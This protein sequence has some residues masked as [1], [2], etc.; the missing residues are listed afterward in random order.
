[1]QIAVYEHTLI[2]KNLQ[3]HIRSILSLIQNKTIPKTNSL[4]HSLP[5]SLTR[6][7]NLLNNLLNEQTTF[8]DRLFTNYLHTLHPGAEHF[9]F[10]GFSK[11]SS[12]AGS[13]NGDPQAGSEVFPLKLITEVWFC[14]KIKITA[15]NQKEWKQEVPLEHSFCTL[16]W[17][18]I[19]FPVNGLNIRHTTQKL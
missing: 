18:W 16:V 15:V 10:L 8:L 19:Q 4:T 6:T 1:M 13:I 5:P 17:L 2:N 9:I 12:R 3:R 14:L 7:N 11:N